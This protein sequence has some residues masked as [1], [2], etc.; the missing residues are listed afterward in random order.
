MKSLIALSALLLYGSPVVF[1]DIG[2]IPV[3]F[4]EKCMGSDEMEDD[5]RIQKSKYCDCM[6]EYFY[7]KYADQDFKEIFEEIVTIC[8][9][10]Y[11]PLN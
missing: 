5:Y 2:P 8:K 10:K 1:A 4:K 7:V 3:A 11:P 9:S 6:G